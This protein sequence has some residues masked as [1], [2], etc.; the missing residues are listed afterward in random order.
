MSNHEDSQAGPSPD[1]VLPGLPEGRFEGREAFRQTVRDALACAAREGWQ[2][3]ALSDTDFADWPLGER[4]VVQSLQNWVRRGRKL[5]LLAGTYDELPRCHPRFVAWRKTWDH[6]IECR[7]CATV[8]RPEMPSVLWT[9]G[10][11]MRRLHVERCLGMATTLP[12]PRAAMAEMLRE[13]SRRSSPGFP[14]TTLGL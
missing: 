3:M 14:V 6:V 10:W 5:T 11:A 7:R 8:D 13:F 9:S 2:E 4:E 1:P 12:E